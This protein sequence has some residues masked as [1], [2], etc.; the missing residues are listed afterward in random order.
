MITLADTKSVQSAA[1]L[2]LKTQDEALIRSAIAGA[3]LTPW[4]AG[5]LP[6]VVRNIY[7]EESASVPLRDGESRY[8]CV[9]ATEGAGKALS[10]CRFVVVRLSVLCVAADLAVQ[11]RDGAAGV[12]RARLL[13][14]ACE[15]YEQGGLLTQEDLGLLLHCDERTVRRDIQLLSKNNIRVPTRGLVQDIGPTLT[16][17]GQAIERWL[18]GEEPVAIARSLFHSLA[19][20]E[21]YLADFQRVSLL[22]MKQMDAVSIAQATHLSSPLVETYTAIYHQARKN[23]AYDYRFTELAQLPAAQKT[24]E[25]SSKKGAL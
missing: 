10:S 9:A 23:L 13:R 20:V 5:V 24:A 25:T 12:R 22:L 4:E 19:A 1:R 3:G 7:F 17:K 16:H 14:F 11:Q 8:T 15:A 21:R 2:Q 18:R 6:E